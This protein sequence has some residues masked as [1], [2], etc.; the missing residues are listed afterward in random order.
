MT[1]KVTSINGSRLLDNKL[2]VILEDMNKSLKSENLSE[3]EIIL[4]RFNEVISKFYKTLNSPL[5]QIRDFRKGSFP[6]IDELNDKFRDV[7]Q[8]LKIIYRELNSL[9]SFISTNFNTLQT[10]A[11]ALKG[12][13][14]K[15]SSDLGD[16]KLYAKDNLGGATYFGESFQNTEKIDY[17]S[18]LYDEDIAA[19][20]LQSGA[21]SLPVDPAKTKTYSLLETTI[22]SGSNGSIGN[23]QELNALLRGELKSISDD[24]ADTWFEYESVTSSTSSLPLILELKLQ[25][26][27]D[28][29]INSLSISTTAFA[30]RTYA[31][32]TKLEVS[33][34]GKEFTDILDQVPSSSFFEDTKDKVVVLDPS[35]GKFSGISKIKIP[36]NKAKY[37]NIILQQDDGYIIKTPSGIKYRKAIGIRGID[38]KGE[39]YKP[40]GEIVSNSFFAQDEIKKVSI[41]ANSQITEG[42][43][44]IRHFISADDGQS[45]NEIQS[46][47]KIKKGI[48][49][50]LNFNIEGV[51]SVSTSTPPSS[52]RH[53]ALLERISNGFSTR[54]GVE[55]TRQNISDFRTISAGTQTITLTQRPIP[56]T[57]NL[58]N[59]S[60]GSVG[61][62][63][64]YLVRSSD[65]ID[66]DD[67]KFIYLPKAPFFLESISLDQEVIFIDN[68]K[69][70]R[71]DDLSLE[72]SDAKTYEFDYINNIIK[73]GD[74]NT[75]KQPSSDIFFGLEREEVQISSDSPRL[76]NLTYDSDGVPESTVIYRLLS[77]KI[78]TNHVL[79]KKSKVN[80]VNLQ[81]LQDISISSDIE[82][83]LS[84][85][86]AYINGSTELS[87]F[88]D[89]SIDYLNGIIFTYSETSED[90]DIIIDITYKP[91]EV[92]S[93][94]I[95]TSEGIEIPEE[96][97]KTST[98]SET[99][100]ITSLTK[101]VKLSNGFIEPRSLRFLNE[102]QSFKTEVSFRGDGEEFNIGL[103][104]A[105]LEGYYT[106]DYKKGII[107]L[108]TPVSNSVIIEYN[109]TNYYA[110]YNIA[111]EV[112]KEKY[113]I[114]E[115]NNQIILTD[116]YVI[117]TFSNSINN[118][119]LRNLFKV[120]Y[121]FIVELTQ[122]P[123]ELEPYFTPLLKDYALAILTKG[124]L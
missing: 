4:G 13:L 32:I 14:R 103:P 35:S 47:E 39:Y 1:D 116:K 26:D 5:L 77:E 112:E 101:T 37:I 30:A 93:N 27:K 120:D 7:E 76:V 67:F 119:T 40:K 50:I 105:E 90:T 75:G 110:E 10:Q 12:R 51:E 99:V 70:F 91:R 33:L 102:I 96:D 74:D 17:E 52:V 3:R 85:E 63:E 121:D 68:E 109:K 59:I 86:K 34:D 19:I 124:Q 118:T 104:T 20:D 84:L 65:I 107:Y 89:Y 113:K 82:G 15:V 98:I 88:G 62:S 95:F 45:W 42:L 23:N 49:E 83:V 64:Y 56:S 100:N 22:G 71:T 79:P 72:A 123:R 58:K 61:T 24:N 60:F 41:I 18:R 28:S 16:F 43:T 114:D 111:V 81:D 115:E 21:I 57:V 108:Y 11:A 48:T 117:Q 87:A 8:D 53:K 54:G 97:Y 29:I 31:R 25:L 94:L 92:L 66:R 46:V 2:A 36:P 122:N 38:I 69:W 55:K 6:N 44:T 9:E 78:K 80:R 73:F 106:V